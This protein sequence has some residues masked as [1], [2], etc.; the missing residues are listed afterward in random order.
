MDP[1]HIKD[2]FTWSLLLSLSAFLFTILA[3]DYY[4]KV[5]SQAS[6]FPWQSK[7]PIESSRSEPT[8]SKDTNSIRVIEIMLQPG[9]T[10][11]NL[12]ENRISPNELYKLIKACK[13]VYPLRHI[14]AGNKLRLFL[15]DE[16]FF[17]LEYQINPKE[18]LCVVKEKEGFSASREFCSYES[19]TC[20]LE[21]RI[22]SSLFVAVEE[23]GERPQ[24]A[25]RLADIFAWDVDFRRALRKGDTFKVVIEKLSRKGKFIEYG[26]IL[27]AQFTNRGHTHRAFLYEDEYGSTAYYDGQ[28]KSVQKR[29]LKSPLRFTRISSGYSESRLHPILNILRPHHGIDYAAPRGTPVMSVADGFVEVTGRSRAAGKYVKIR[30][31]S[32]YETVYNHLS[33]FAKGISKGRRVKQGQCIGY[34]GS[35]GYA[36][37]PHLDFRMKKNGRNINPLNVKSPPVKS[38][39]SGD[40]ERFTSHIRPLLAVLREENP[41]PAPAHAA[42]L[43]DKNSDH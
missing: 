5:K 11:S 31:G 14:K 28:G 3:L 16:S 17:R 19:R 22:T 35:T 15:K 9:D 10:L 40:M 42:A 12:I 6:L 7:P 29:F 43:L 13:K 25:T 8:S 38:I 23:I 1:D 32:I 21:G 33:R 18:K 4:L 2:R 20:I 24:L 37:G 30:H 36:T 27:A 26:K 34:V 39:S 41:S